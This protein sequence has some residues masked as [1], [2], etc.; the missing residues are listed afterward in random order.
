[1]RS[2]KPNTSI[3]R[4]RTRR[5]NGSVATARSDAGWFERAQ[6]SAGGHRARAGTRD[7]VRSRSLAADTCAPHSQQHRAPPKA[8]LADAMKLASGAVSDATS[9]GLDIVAADGLVALSGCSAR[10]T[11]AGGRNRSP[12]RHWRSRRSRR[13]A[14][15][16]SGTPS[17]RRVSPSAGKAA[18]AIALVDRRHCLRTSR[19]TTS[20]RDVR[21][22]HRRAI[23]LAT[24]QFDSSQ[25]DVSRSAG[26]RGNRQGRRT[27]SPPQLGSRRYRRRSG[28][29]P[30]ALQLRQR[31]EDIFDARAISRR[32]R[33][34]WRTAP[35]C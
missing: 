4:H 27:R 12:T 28:Q 17:T 22:S 24:G 3:K 16:R 10:W 23:A 26:A 15:D 30:E 9:A 25:R 18:E 21:P 19:R 32:C 1:M 31:A 7:D 8:S 13:E 20:A 11:E 34:P 33:T 14:D 5:R 29:Y 35:I 2:R 6:A